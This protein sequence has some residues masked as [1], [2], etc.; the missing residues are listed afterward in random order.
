MT[1]FIS[2]ITELLD[3]RNLNSVK[4]FNIKNAIIS[5]KLMSLLLTQLALNKNSKDFFENLLITDSEEGGDIFDIKVNKVYQVVEPDQDLT[6]KTKAELV[7]A[8]YNSV[9]KKAM[10]I[11]II[12]NDETIY[13]CHNQDEEINITLEPNDLLIY[14]KY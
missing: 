5:N 12:K 6:F 2:F 8:F 9:N 11:G 7:Q 4:D 1:V 14:I 13:L 3:S 10:L